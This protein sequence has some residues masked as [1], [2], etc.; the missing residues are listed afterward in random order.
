[1][2]FFKLALLWSG[3]SVLLLGCA[4][5]QAT[6]AVG[7]ATAL[8]PTP[9]VLPPEWT[10]TAEQQLIQIFTPTPTPVPT[11]TVFASGPVEIG[12]SVAGRP[13]QVYRFGN[14]SVQRLIV[15]GIH[16]GYEWNTIAL[17]RKLIE[18]IEDNPEVIPADVELTILPALNPDGEARSR[19]A[20]GRANENGVDLNRN[21]PSFWQPDWPLTGCWN[22]LPITAGEFPRSEPEVSALLALI[23]E[24]DITALISY[25]SAA[26]GIFPGG[27]PPDPRSLRLA[28]AVAAVSPYPYPPIDTGCLYTGQFAD[29]ASANVIAAVDIELSTHNSLDYEINL[30][31]MEAFLAWRP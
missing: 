28:E 22:T 10:P 23:Q 2:S 5:V 24:K 14:G 30:N 9:S 16:G 29:W 21:W 11:P 18:F 4:P 8:P 17:A 15:A 27:K 20:A 26:L 13:L 6:Q 12:T 19:Y 7:E 1:M 25:H 31:V 3:I